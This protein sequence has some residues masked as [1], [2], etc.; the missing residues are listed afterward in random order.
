MLLTWVWGSA[1]RIQGFID[2]NNPVEWLFGTHSLFTPL[3][4]FANFFV[5]AATAPRVMPMIKKFFR[6]ADPVTNDESGKEKSVKMSDKSKGNMEFST[7][8]E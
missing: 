3:Q 5:Y 6:F 1:N 2:P 8:D 4:G 7:A